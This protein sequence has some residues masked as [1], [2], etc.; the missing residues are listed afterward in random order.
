MGSAPVQPFFRPWI[1]R[2]AD[3]IPDA[4]V[5]LR[6]LQAVAPPDLAPT[7]VRRRWRRSLRLVLP[8]LVAVPLVSFVLL[9]ATP[10]APRESTPAAA[11][12]PQA[13]LPAPVAIATVPAVWQVEHSRDS[14]SYSNGLRIDNRYSV[15][16]HPRSYRTFPLDPSGAAG[17]GSQPVGI[18]FHT[19]ESRQA[20]FEEQQNR[21][22][23][24][25]GESLLEYIQHKRAYNFVI[26]RFGR[27]Y[28][29][30]LESDAANHAGYSV[31]S[32]E[33]WL[34]LNLNE[35]FL[36]VSVEAQTEPGQIEPEMSPAQ[37]HAAAMLTE[38]LRS[39]YGI[40]ASNCVTHA[41][42]SVNPSNMRI[43]YHTDWAS[44][45]PFNG[46]GLP[47]NYARPLSAVVLFGFEA[48]RSFDRVAGARMTAAVDLSER[49]Q[50]EQAAAAGL[51]LRA[52]R[53]MLQ[54]RYWRL[55]GE[56][57]S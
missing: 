26:D 20:P 14:E 41:Q 18:V 27:V 40:S 36:A 51:S 38:M 47:D 7:P 35:S 8:L 32:D 11:I 46:V 48:D 12:Q 29:I 9:R 10:H 21:V 6:F 34:Y 56:L 54:N 24:R 16:N 49:Q 22:L 1:N 13:S 39:R 31:W 33:R 17:R 53:K 43:G 44:S 19:T 55:A 57:H 50:R 4:V 42:V 25:I 3:H 23:Q 15:S 5:R 2:F 37:V 45:F 28:R 52:Y 30:V